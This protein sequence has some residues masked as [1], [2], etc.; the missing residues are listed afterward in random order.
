MARALGVQRVV[1]V[2]QLRGDEVPIVQGLL[3][4][5]GGMGGVV[6]TGQVAR[7]DDQLAVA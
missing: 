3:Q 7:D 4:M 1:E 5:V 2:L 6:R